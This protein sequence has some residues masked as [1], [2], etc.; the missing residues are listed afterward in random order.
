MA[1]QPNRRP[2]HWECFVGGH[3]TKPALIL[4][5]TGL[6]TWSADFESLAKWVGEG[7][8]AADPPAE[9][10]LAQVHR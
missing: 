10:S 9:M 2:E 1:T 6:I 5:R 4:Q 3:Y 8:R 7:W